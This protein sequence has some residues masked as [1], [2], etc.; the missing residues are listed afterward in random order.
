[1]HKKSQNTECYIWHVVQ[2]FD[3]RYYLLYAS[4]Q[5]T[6]IAYNTYKMYNFECNLQ[7]N[8]DALRNE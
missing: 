1:M 7:H 5:G 6:L 4:S 3:I 8:F 2:K